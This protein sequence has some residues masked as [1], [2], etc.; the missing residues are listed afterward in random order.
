[1]IWLEIISCRSVDSKKRKAAKKI[2][3]DL[4][5]K[6]VLTAKTE[7]TLCHHAVLNSDLALIINHNDACIESRGS[8]V[9]KLVATILEEYGLVSHSV[10]IEESLV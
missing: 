2:L 7:V 9:G 6:R 1:M 10:W 4:R 5:E 3:E 8:E